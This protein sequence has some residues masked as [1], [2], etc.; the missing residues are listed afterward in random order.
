MR[1]YYA[2]LDE[3]RF[4]DAWGV[5]SPA[6]QHSFGSFAKWKAGY[7][8]TTKSEPRELT[9]RPAGDAL[10][11]NLRLVAHEQNCDALQAFRV[12]WRLEQQ[13]GGWHVAGLQGAAL[14]G[15]PCE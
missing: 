5:L 12:T 1:D 2:A 4:D 8:Q 13:A 3:Q 10:I 15:R 14:Q 9:T 6:V 7:A 11:V